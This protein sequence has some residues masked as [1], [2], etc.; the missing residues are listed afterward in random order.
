MSLDIVSLIESNPI[1]RFNQNHQ[2]KLIEKLQTNFTDYE[3]QMFLSSFYCY[4][5]Y[6]K[7]NDFVIDVDNIW[8]WLGFTNKANSKITIERN[9]NIDKDYKIFLSKNREKQFESEEIVEIEEN[10][11]N[12]SIDI[13]K[14]KSKKQHGGHN[15]ETIMLNITTFKNLC[16][17][18]GT[19]RAD[20]IHNY[21][22]K[23]EGTLY[24]IIEEETSELKTQV[25]QFGEENSYLKTQMIKFTIGLKTSLIM[26]KIK[27]GFY[28]RVQ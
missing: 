1:A 11:D 18:A 12:V 15:K 9:F 23:L 19:K 14:K 20:E 28:I 6:D 16:L 24:E 3:Q 21:F 17:K 22:I 7:L 4:L 10:E 13:K 26:E 8:K 27:I 5:K 25:L 2:S